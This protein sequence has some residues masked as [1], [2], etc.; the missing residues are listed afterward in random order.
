MIESAELPD[1]SVPMPWQSDLW[2]Q[3]Q[4]QISL[5][6]LP[7]ALLLSGP[8]GT[9]KNRLALALSRLL[10]CQSPKL[11]HNCG[12]CHPCEMTRAGTHGDFRWL[13]P[14]EKSRVIKI[15]QIRDV[16]DFGNKTANFGRR[17]V[18]VFSPAESMNANA[19]NALLKAL[20]EPAPDTYLIMVCHRL[21]G[22]S[23]TIRSRTQL[24]RFPI[25]SVVESL[26]WLDGLTQKRDESEQLLECANGR[27]LRAQQLYFDGGME[28]AA[29][30][31]AALDKLLSGRGTVPQLSSVLAQVP[32]EDALAQLAAYLQRAIRSAPKTGITMHRTRHFFSILDEVTR[33]QQAVHAGSNPNA[34]LLLESVLAQF[35]NQL[36]DTRA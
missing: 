19:G 6:K 20:E 24:L 8:E 29:A 18:I 32:L 21:H 30:V 9:G 13:Q 27:P 2:D 25:P 1:I 28:T 33:Q 17:K 23:A 5:E 11:G 16:I 26:D 34:Q 4:D 22:L 15:D 36:G 7:H 31:P 3:L 10:L 12:R 14:E 35:H